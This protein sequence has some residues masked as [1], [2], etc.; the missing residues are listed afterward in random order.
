MQDQEFHTN[1]KKTKFGR[2]SPSYVI[3][4]AEEID[5]LYYLVI[6]QFMQFICAVVH[7]VFATLSL[8]TYRVSQNLCLYR[9]SF[10]NPL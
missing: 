9:V 4:D 6:V 5:T 1:V 8:V 10:K 3:V 7:A 2:F